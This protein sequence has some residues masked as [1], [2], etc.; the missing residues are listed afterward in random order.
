MA[1]SPKDIIAA[2]AL[3]ERTV[4]VCVRGDLLADIDTLTEELQAELADAKA[5]G[6]LAGRNK[7]TP[8]A[9]ELTEAIEAKRVEMTEH[10]ITFRLRALKPSVWRA[11]VAKHPPA[12]NSG[13]VVDLLGFM[14]DA[15]PAS[16]VEPELDAEDWK[17]LLEEERLPVA[18]VGKLIDAVWDLNYSAVDVP[19]SRMP[20]AATRTSS[21]G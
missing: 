7:S 6:R 13:M 3:P 17:A 8:R 9:Q 1:L 14:G 19:K 16:T 20:S 12:K 21:A 5:N 2:A 18:E 10:T 11:L 4:V 15:I